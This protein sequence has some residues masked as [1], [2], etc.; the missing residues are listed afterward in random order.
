MKTESYY[1]AGLGSATCTRCAGTFRRR[2]DEAWKRLCYAC[3]KGGRDD[4]AYARGYAAGVASAKAH[5]LF[6]APKPAALPAGLDKRIRQLLQLC[7]PDKHAGSPLSNDV[8]QWL[9]DVKREM[10]P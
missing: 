10:R 6:T 1:G 3:W 4:D 7:H 9:N 5:A 8:T 2:A